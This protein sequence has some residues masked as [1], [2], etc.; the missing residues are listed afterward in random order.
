MD[1]EF[2]RDTKMEAC[3]LLER[4]GLME[5]EVGERKR[6]Q[7]RKRREEAMEIDCESV[8]VQDVWHGEVI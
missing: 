4:R 6:R 7:R 3:F 2:F 8:V 5:R 1:R